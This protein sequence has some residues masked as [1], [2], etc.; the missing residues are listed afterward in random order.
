LGHLASGR[1][2]SLAARGERVED[3]YSQLVKCTDGALP[4]FLEHMETVCGHV[5]CPDDLDDPL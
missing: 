1:I 3:F 5:R 4:R 2:N